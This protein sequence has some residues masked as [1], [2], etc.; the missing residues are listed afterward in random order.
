MKKA[1]GGSSIPALNAKRHGKRR[2]L[3]KLYEEQN[4]AK[5]A[6]T[7]LG[8]ERI[9][10]PRGVGALYD[11]QHVNEKAKDQEEKVNALYKLRQALLEEYKLNKERGDYAALRK[12]A[13]S[14]EKTNAQLK[15]A[16]GTR[17]PNTG[18]RSAA[19]RPTRLSPS[20]G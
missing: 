8:K 3:R 7:E 5:E 10:Q 13:D 4:K 9:A 19:P 11:A 16:I 6:G 15:E 12:T 18:R 17:D 14:L 2:S 20:S 1:S